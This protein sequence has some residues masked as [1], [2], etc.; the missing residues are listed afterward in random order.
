MSLALS[1]KDRLR[2]AHKELKQCLQ[3]NFRVGYPRSS[4]DSS[5]EL[6]LPHDLRQENFL[7]EVFSKGMFTE[8]W[9]SPNIPHLYKGLQKSGKT[10]NRFLEI[11]SFEG[12][13]T[14][15][16][17]RYLARHSTAPSVTAIDIFVNNKEHGDIGKRFDSNAGLFMQGVDV[18]KIKSDSAQALS[19]LLVDKQEYDLV[20][21]DGSHNVLNVI[22][23]ASLCWKM[24]R[25]EG[26]IIFD[27]YFWFID[28]KS[29]HVLSAVNA[30]LDLIAG[31]FKVL[32]VFYQVILQKTVNR[33]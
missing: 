20:Y 15:W 6:A 19:K 13:S 21:V 17:A 2:L 22:I 25:N 24:L 30:F 3:E 1:E 12:L 4:G 32:N 7:K 18:N 23:D 33:E 5:L 11:G 14:C 8:D 9:F 10:F 26:V 28:K 16:F 27:D 31:E 29:G